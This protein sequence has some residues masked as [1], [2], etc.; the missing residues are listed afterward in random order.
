MGASDWNR[1]MLRDLH[2]MRDEFDSAESLRLISVG[3]ASWVAVV[4]LLVVVGSAL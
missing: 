2:T 4:V 3:L 1:P